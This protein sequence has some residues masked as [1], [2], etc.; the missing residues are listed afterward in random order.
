MFLA[1]ER[2]FLTCHMCA[3]SVYTRADKL[4]PMVPIITDYRVHI[5]G[6]QGK[7][8]IYICI[9][10]CYSINGPTWPPCRVSPTMPYSE[11]CLNPTRTGGDPK[12]LIK[13]I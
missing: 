4:L 6:L 9:Y 13:N 7:I 3:Y 11:K 10:I 2:I 5:L 1:S 8:Y 12:K